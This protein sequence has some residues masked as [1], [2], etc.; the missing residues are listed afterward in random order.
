MPSSVADESTVLRRVRTKQIRSDGSLAKSSFVQRE[1]G[2]DRAG[3]SVSIAEQ[4]LTELHRSRFEI[5]D[6]C[7]F[8]LQVLQVRH[9]GLDVESAPV[10]E[11]PAHALIIGIP[12]RT[13]GEAEFLA[14][15]RC[16]QLLAGLAKRYSFASLST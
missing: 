3:L 2:Q 7:A 16:A 9:F 5:P 12:D 14:M 4:S 10:T 8:A 11:D 15:E 6:H 1:K 13:A